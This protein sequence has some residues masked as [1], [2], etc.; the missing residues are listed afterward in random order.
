M[1]LE[2]GDNESYYS[3]LSS[4]AKVDKISIGTLSDV[5]KLDDYD[6]VFIGIH[7]SNPNSWKSYNTSE[8]SKSL[9]NTIAQKNKIVLRIFTNPYSLIDLNIKKVLAVVLVY[10]NSKQFQGIVV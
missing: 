8:L 9:L 1:P 7:K 10:Q 3:Y 6:I 4:Y 5:S 2:K